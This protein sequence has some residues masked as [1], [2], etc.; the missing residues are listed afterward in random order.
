MLEKN[1]QRKIGEGSINMIKINNKNV[2][3]LSN[4]S[5]QNNADSSSSYDLSKNK[6]PIVPSINE[7][8]SIDI[9]IPN[10]S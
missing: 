3:I 1:L 10:L 8:H 4:M 7:K 5:Q 2:R 6:L 9:Y